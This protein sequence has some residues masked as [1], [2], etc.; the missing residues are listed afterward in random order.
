M[1]EQILAK[2]YA[3][4]V[5]QLGTDSRVDIA[6]EL[7]VLTEAINASNELEN[8]LFL[9]IFTP[10]EKSS[11]L[12]VLLGKLKLSSL[13][14][15]FVNFLVQEKRINV[16][17]LIYKEVIVL[18]DHEKGFLRGTI[19][20]NDERIDS[21]SAEELKQYLVAKLGK[22][23]TLEYRQ[24]PKITAGYRVTVEDMQLD[25]TFDNQLEQFRRSVLGE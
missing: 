3:K 24:N 19:E 23:A 11:V 5:M 25:A 2:V 4:S 8:L 22:E 14:C 21:N 1:K 18:D 10:E 20:G 13:A 16:L 7:T 15:S 17:P 12:E 9:D 6:K